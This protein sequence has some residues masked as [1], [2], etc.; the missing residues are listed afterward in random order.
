M[1]SRKEL[2]YNDSPVILNGIGLSCYV[3]H[4]EEIRQY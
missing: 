4:A 1:M 3:P 2:P